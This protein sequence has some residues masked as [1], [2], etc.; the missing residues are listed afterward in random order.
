MFSLGHQHR[1][2]E[3]RSQ[4]C[5]NH[6]SRSAVGAICVQLRPWPGP[7]HVCMCPQSLQLL[8]LDPS[9]LEHLSVQM[10]H[11]CSLYQ[12]ICRDLIHG[13]P[14]CKGRFHLFF[15]SCTACGAQLWFQSHLCMW[16]TLRHLLPVQMKRG[17]GVFDCLGGRERGWCV[18][19]EALM[20]APPFGYHSGCI[21]LRGDNVSSGSNQAAER[22]NYVP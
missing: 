17:E 8:K 14:S 12:A 9:H 3:V 10:F 1:P 6:K 11:N 16:A 18:G 2:T 19:T 4:D 20:V 22:L 13:S 21:P 5:S 7:T 15:L